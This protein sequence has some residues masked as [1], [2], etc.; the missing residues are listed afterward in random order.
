[1]PNTCVLSGG[2]GNPSNFIVPVMPT[3]FQIW[4]NP[5]TN[6]KYYPSIHGNIKNTTCRG[7]VFLVLS[8]F[9]LI[10]SDNVFQVDMYS[11]ALFIQQAIGWNL[12]LAVFLLLGMT[13]LSTLT[14]KDHKLL[15]CLHK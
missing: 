6:C 9:F 8:N 15:F 1:M 2:E 4:K 13:V 3:V 11:G 5:T 7:L 10:L 12:Y 14:G